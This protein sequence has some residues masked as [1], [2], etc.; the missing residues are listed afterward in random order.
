MFRNYLKIAFRNLWKNKG[1]AAINIGGLTIGLTGF[2]LLLLY[3]NYERSYDKWSPQLKNIYQVYTLSSADSISWSD[4][5]DTRLGAPLRNRLA[6]VEAVTM[7]SAPYDNTIAIDADNKMFLENADSLRDSDSSFFKVFPYQFIAGNPDHALDKINTIVLTKSLANK[8]F[9]TTDDVTGRTVKIKRGWWD[10]KGT[11]YKITGVVNNLTSPTSVPVSAV[12][13]S[14]YNDAG[15]SSPNT[16]RYANVYIKLN[17]DQSLDIFSKQANKVYDDALGQLLQ[18]RNSSLSEY[19]KSGKRY[20]IS[21]QPLPS[22]HLH[23]LNGKSVMDKIAPALALSLLLLFIAIINFANLA[24]AQVIQR[25]KEAGVRKVLGANKKAL[26]FQFLLEAATQCIVALLTALLIVELFLP[27]LNQFFNINISL[28]AYHHAISTL[29]WQLI[30]IILLTTLLSGIYPALFLAGY[31]PVKVLKGNLSRGRSGLVPRNIL[32][33]IQFLVAAVFIA[34]III[35]QKQVNYMAHADL[36]FQPDGLINLKVH[37]NKKLFD[38]LKAIPDIEYAGSASQLMGNSSGFYTKIKYE[39]EKVNLN[40]AT[41]NMET[42]NAMKVHLLKGRLFSSQYGQDKI[43]SVILNESA[44]KLL[45]GNVVGKSLYELD[46]I[47]RHIVGVIADYHYEGFDK[48]IL[49]TVYALRHSHG[50]SIDMSN[51][52]VRVNTKNYTQVIAAIKKVWDD[53]YP[54]FPLEYV[55]MNDSFRHVIADD[56]RF[57][58]IVSTFTLLS[59]IL[60]LVG[61]FALSAYITTRRTKEI[62]IRR[63]LG[64][65]I[66][67]I[68][69]LLNKNFVVL[70]IIANVIAWPV[71]YLLAKHWLNGFAY[72]INVS[73]PPF[74][75]ATIVSVLLTVLTVSLQ[76]WKAA[77]ANP[78]DALKY[79]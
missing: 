17:K 52:L 59:L 67:D 58:K 65:S 48:K 56:I 28:W 8:W 74:I 14:G 43:N 63:V 69:K 36:G 54:G 57:R 21:F 2:I 71:A 32:I 61:I 64:A 55:F 23:P 68:L 72:R 24:T 53:L 37:Y 25:G 22:V 51:M 77:T 46:T 30:I 75:I 34:G 62:G 73:L 27:F 4:Q 47:Q 16:T 44:A 6:G 79:E 19:I 66:P 60:S 11:Y 29:W 45:G 15:S 41:V 7:V 42:L 50:P 76:A 3:I 12:Y 9:G 35:I 33:I 5:C 78:V 20:G 38:R 70:V 26:V 49:P 39:G 1:Y 40:V 13:R 10:K 18:T 31:D